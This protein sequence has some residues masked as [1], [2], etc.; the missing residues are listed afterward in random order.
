MC[1]VKISSQAGNDG[2]N[3]RLRQFLRSRLP[4]KP[5]FKVNAIIQFEIHR[6]AGEMRNG[7]DLWLLTATKPKSS[8]TKRR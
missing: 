5:R 2:M 6:Q 8:L 4:E 7:Y 1:N 3:E